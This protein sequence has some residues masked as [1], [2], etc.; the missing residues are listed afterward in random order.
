[1]EVFWLLCWH[2]PGWKLPIWWSF[3]GEIHQISANF[4]KNLQKIL[5]KSSKNTQKPSKILKTSSKI[6]EKSSNFL[7]K[8][9]K[10]PQKTAGPRSLSAGV[11]PPRGEYLYTIIDKK[12]NIFFC[13]RRRCREGQ[14][15]KYILYFY[16]LDFFHPKDNPV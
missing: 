4:R 11:F 16:Y 14:K 10:N 6:V 5:K 12:K 3:F 7:K 8:S 1:M 13:Q 9:S 15:K 2:F